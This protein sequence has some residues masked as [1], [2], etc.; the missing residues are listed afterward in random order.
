MTMN[1][2]ILQACPLPPPLVG[3]LP[4]L[5]PVETL[6]DAPDQ[7]AFLREHGAEFTVLITTGT[8]GAD[9]AL[10]DALPNL[11]AICSLGVGYDAI[12]LDAVRARG[13]MLS[14]TP[15]VLN[16]CVADL[17]MGLLID[18]V[19]GI[20]ASDRHVRRGDWPRVGPTMPSTRVSG[21]RLGMLGMGRVGQ[22]IARRAIGF[23]M[24]I[25][26]HTRSAKPELPWQHEPSL[27][28]LAQWCDFLIVAC[29]GSPET[30]HLVSAEVLKALGPNGYLINV[31]RGSVV[32]EKAL[33]AALENSHLGGA[34]L[35]VFEN[36]PEV[37]VELLSN[38]RVVVLPHVGSATRETRAAMCE[39]VLRNVERFVREGSL[40]APVK[41]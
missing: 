8:Q 12:D 27:L 29:P 25:R 16:D 5:C 31:A 26:Y 20:S 22:V 1:Q 23:D 6:S 14:N 39:L 33:V 30:Y 41:L 24:E 18:T 36:E 7:A 21:K 17:A 32:D 10:I 11:K 4:A 37:P 3:K 13:V 2:K 15:D 40:V 9:K 35:D 19:R 34:G 28:A 38:E